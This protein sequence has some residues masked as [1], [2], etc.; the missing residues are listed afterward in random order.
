M[1][2]R[3]RALITNDDGI[4]S[5]GLAALAKAV[6]DAGYE[7]TI[8]APASQ[9]SGTS[10]SLTATDGGGRINV[11]KREPGDYVAVYAVEATPALITLL[12]VNGGFGGRPDLVV[13]GINHGA[14]VGHAVL[15]SGTLGA[16]L[17]AAYHGITA[18]AVSLDVPLTPV[19][20]L[21]WDTAAELTKRLLPE[22]SGL[23]TGSAANF[24]VPDLA[25]DEIKGVRTA[26][27]ADFG[28][29]QISLAETGEDFLRTQIA[30][31]TDTFA[32]DSD[33][34]LLNDNYAT[35][36]AINA[37]TAVPFT[38]RITRLGLEALSTST[39]VGS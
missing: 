28:I 33:A 35:I 30:E 17:T 16:A 36:T 15:H 21:R 22:L 11:H 12:A 3:P 20:P 2:N 19:D 10:A 6:A 32:E 18:L 5:P 23:P 26:R 29:V 38:P 25:L 14:N 39:E 9:S 4:D 31:S 27:L 7:V 8:A 37:I 13:S 1:S 24:N 34:A